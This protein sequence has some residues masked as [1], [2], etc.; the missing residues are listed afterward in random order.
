M[1]NE[2]R[3]QTINMSPAPYWYRIEHNKDGYVLYQEMLEEGEGVTY[4]VVEIVDIYENECFLYGVLRHITEQLNMLE[5]SD[6]PLKCGKD[7][8][9]V[10]CH[11]DL[12]EPERELVDTVLRVVYTPKEIEDSRYPRLDFRYKKIRWN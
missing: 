1:Q 10:L 7:F 5:K 3:H 11:M 9:T 6:I 8:S 4:H 2:A 12:E